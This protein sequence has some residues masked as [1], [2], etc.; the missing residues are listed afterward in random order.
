MT[1]RAVHLHRALLKAL[2]G[3]VHWTSPTN[4]KPLILD[5]RE[6]ES[7]RLRV[8]MY[9]LVGGAGERARREYKIVLRVRDQAVG[10]YGS[11]DHSDGRFTTVVGYDADLDVFVFWD[12]SLHPRFKNGGN[13]QVRDQVVRKAAVY[14]TAEQ[15]R[16]LTNGA[17]EAVLVCQSPD[18]WR[19][20]ETRIT[21]TGG[22]EEGECLTFLN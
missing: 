7:L 9:S 12:A 1:A 8:Y 15:V 6:P 18:L 2:G 11:F 19:T 14:G 21:T 22:I 3:R 20:L 5:L 10:Q 17:K 16:Y 13:L 4:E